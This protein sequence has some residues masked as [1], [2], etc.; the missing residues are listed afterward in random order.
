MDI[1]QLELIVVQRPSPRTLVTE[2]QRMTYGEVESNLNTN[3][4]GQENKH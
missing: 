1:F 4:R 2:Q 3:Y